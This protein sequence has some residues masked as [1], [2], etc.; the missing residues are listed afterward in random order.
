[1][2]IYQRTAKV[3]AVQF[4]E[5]EYT[6][7]SSKYPHVRDRVML[8]EIWWNKTAKDGRHYIAVPSSG[9]HTF[10]LSDNEIIVQEGDYI[11]TEEI[12]AVYTMKEEV[13]ERLYERIDEE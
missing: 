1:M 11:I 8:S 4:Y 12:G 9:F 2:P 5:K 6:K 13:F 3:Q 7:D 10:F